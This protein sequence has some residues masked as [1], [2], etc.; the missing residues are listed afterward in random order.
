MIENCLD[1]VFEDVPVDVVKTGMLST[2]ETVQTVV[3]KLG[4]EIERGAREGRTVGVVIDPVMVSTSGSRLIAEDAV[5][6]Y[7][8]GLF[9]LATVITPNLLEALFI[10][11]ELGLSESDD[12]SAIQSIADIKQ[13]AADLYGL[14]CQAVLVKGGH[15][16]L[17][18]DLKPAKEG[19]VP[20]KIVDVLYDGEEYYVFENPFVGS[21]NTHGTGCT[22]ASA[23][24]SNLGHGMSLDNAVK[25]GIRY[26]QRAI[27]TAPNIGQGHGPVNHIHNLQIRPYTP[28]H[29]VDYLLN[30]PKVKPHWDLYVNH[31]FTKQVG[32]GTLPVET[33]KYFLTQD[34]LYLIHYARA[35]S[36]AG[37]KSNDID[38]AAKSA[39][40]VQTIQHE[41]RLHVAYCATFGLPEEDIK[42]A[43]ESIQCYAYTRFILDTGLQDDWTGLEFALSP[44]LLGYVE[45]ANNIKADPQSVP[46][47]PYWRWVEEYSKPEFLVASQAGID[48]LEAAVLDASP[49][50]LEQLVDIFATA[51]RMECDFWSY[52][53]AHG[54]K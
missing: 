31:P 38:V 33:F 50:R 45:A 24:A 18:D 12:A 40:I 9:P 44:C 6:E 13:L 25:N 30:H 43:K 21:Q 7:I 16:G 22:L 26:V 51:T 3:R 47:N 54:S 37:Y 2:R 8:R 17:T 4:A 29:F 32:Q 5:G 1:A 41:T 20:T 39:Q 53:L 11:K 48:L 35:H 42:N 14:K 49:A 52:S 23:I 34:Y 15:I 27:V 28:G 10:R 19:D 36:L 46:G